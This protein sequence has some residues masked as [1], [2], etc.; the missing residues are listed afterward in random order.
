MSPKRLKHVSTVHIAFH[1][2]GRSGMTAR[3]ILSRVIMQFIAE[4][5][6]T[7]TLLTDDYVRS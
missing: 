3:L 2:L 6:R 1:G 4:R 5:Y 7:G